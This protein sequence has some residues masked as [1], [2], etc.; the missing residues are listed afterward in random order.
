MKSLIIKRSVV[1]GRHRTSVSVED[2]F[3]DDLRQIARAQQ[4]TLSKLIAEIDE[5]RQYNN[6]SSAIRVFVLHLRA[7]SNLRSPI[8]ARL[9]RRWPIKERCL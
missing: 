8:A 2:A 5:N 6:L 4:L 3:W 7:K 9:N 1:I